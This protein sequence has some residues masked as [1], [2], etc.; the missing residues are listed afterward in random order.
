MKKHKNY[1]LKK[2][3]YLTIIRK[4]DLRLS[5]KFFLTPFLYVQTCEILITFP[6]FSSLFSDKM[7]PAFGFGAQI[8]PSWQVKRWSEIASITL[9]TNVSKAKLFYSF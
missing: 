2:C 7:F 3:H 8:P 6:P 9:Y 1:Y 4:L 5:K